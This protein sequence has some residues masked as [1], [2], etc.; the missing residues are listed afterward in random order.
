[1]NSQFIDGKRH[2]HDT[3]NTNSCINFVQ[4]PKKRR[5]LSEMII[6]Y[7]EMFEYID[8]YKKNQNITIKRIKYGSKSIVAWQH[9]T[10]NLKESMH[11]GLAVIYIQ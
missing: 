3:F 7:F 8:I 10:H 9:N 4:N 2:I 5:Y 1:M 11:T 6:M